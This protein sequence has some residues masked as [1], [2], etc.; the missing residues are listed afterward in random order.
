MMRRLA[1]RWIR[2]FATELAPTDM[3]I[4]FFFQRVKKYADLCRGLFQNR[5]VR[6]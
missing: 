5:H 3:D 4:R 6:L 1:M 2:G